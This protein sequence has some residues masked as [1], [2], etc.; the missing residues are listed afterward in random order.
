[1][2]DQAKVAIVPGE[3]FGAPG[4]AR[5]SFALGDDDLGEG[6]ARIGR[7]ARPGLLSMPTTVPYGSW[8][9]LLTTDL[10]IAGAVGLG[11]VAVGDDDIW[12]SELRPEQGGAVVVV[13]H[14]PGGATVDAVPEGYSARTRVHEYGG[15]AW[16]LHD[17]ALV[18][19]NWSDQRLYKIV[20]D[21]DPGTFRAPH[22][23]TP[24]PDQPHGARYADGVT[25]RRRSVDHLRARAARCAGSH[26]GPATRSWPS[27]PRSAASPSCS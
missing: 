12:W 13:R 1:M 5:L 9:S 2:L 18:F 25:Q 10:V 27:T 7:P 14:T 26:R 4:Y 23:L 6:V 24:E 8:P 16:W 3:A 11:E 21:V 20:P 19:A 22:P 17:D 15:G